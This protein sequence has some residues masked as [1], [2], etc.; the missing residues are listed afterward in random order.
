MTQ[1]DPTPVDPISAAWNTVASYDTYQEAQAAVD[2]LSDDQFPVEHLDIVG[3]DLRLVERVTGR[4]TR[5][6]AAAAGAASG[7]WFGLF[8]GLLVSLFTRGPAWLG[9]ILGGLL[10]G[11]LWG[12][13]FGFVGHAATGG[14][15]DFSSTQA[16]VA[17]RYDVIARGG[18]AEQARAAL[19]RAGVPTGRGA[20]GT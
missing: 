1:F 4:L 6:K 2:R 7:A 18:H 9:L 14:R 10:I 17:S 19:R 13:V 11:A 3:S 5:G 15:R 12:A 16:L 20:A 8:M